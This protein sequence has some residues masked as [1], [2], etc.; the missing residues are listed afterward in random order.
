MNSASAK[1]YFGVNG[2][3]RAKGTLSFVPKYLMIDRLQKYGLIGSKVRRTPQ[4]LSTLDINLGFEGQ[5]DSFE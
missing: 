1:W 4:E 5:G 2:K 3:D